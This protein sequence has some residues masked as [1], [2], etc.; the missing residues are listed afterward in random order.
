VTVVYGKLLCGAVVVVVA[1]SVVVYNNCIFAFY[2]YGTS[3]TA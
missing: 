1:V 2:A 3:Y